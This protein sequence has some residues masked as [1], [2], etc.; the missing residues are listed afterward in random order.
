V[1][2]EALKLQGNLV[3]E[4]NH[5]V[6]L[7]NHSAIKLTTEEDQLKWSKICGSGYYTVKLGYATRI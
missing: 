7:L 5:Y 4:W 2:I 6:N 3:E 1:T